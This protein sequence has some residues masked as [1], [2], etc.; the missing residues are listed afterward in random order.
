MPGLC[1]LISWGFVLLTKLGSLRQQKTET[2]SNSVTGWPKPLFETFL[3]HFSKSCDKN[4]FKKCVKKLMWKSAWQSLWFQTPK[5]MAETD[6]VNCPM[7]PNPDP[8]LSVASLGKTLNL[9]LLPMGPS[10]PCSHLLVCVRLSFY[11]V[12]STISC[13]PVA[14][15]G[16]KPAWKC[17]FNPKWK[18]ILQSREGGRTCEI[19]S[20]D[21]SGVTSVSIRGKITLDLFTPLWPHYKNTQSWQDRGINLGCWLR[22]KTVPQATFPSSERNLFGWFMQT[23]LQYKQ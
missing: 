22:A 4:H 17:I 14:L 18:M 8:F 5:M 23:L 21:R 10:A 6:R 16:E 19:P 20:S 9:K 13:N 7:N 2:N 3:K 12:V 1:S 11:P 15:V